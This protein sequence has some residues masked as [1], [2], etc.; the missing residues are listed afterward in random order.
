MTYV[1]R[2]ELAELGLWTDH[3]VLREVLQESWS[4]S[5]NCPGN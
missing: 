4:L 1:L 5:G 2:H 3:L